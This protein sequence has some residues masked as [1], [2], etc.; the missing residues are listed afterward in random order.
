MEHLEGI[1]WD[2]VKYDGFCEE[3]EG[4]KPKLSKVD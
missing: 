4:F 3:N 1:V 2:W